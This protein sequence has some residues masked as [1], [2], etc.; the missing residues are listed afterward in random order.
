LSHYS[1]QEEV[2]YGCTVSG[3]PVDLVGAE[4]I[5]GMLVNTLPVQVKVSPEQSL[6]EWL[7]QLQTQLLEMRQYEYSSLVDVQGWSEVPRGVSLFESIV[8]FENLPVPQGLREGEKS[9]K[10]VD[11]TNFYKINYPL[12]VV[13]VPVFPLVIGINYD[14]NRLEIATINGILTHF[15]ILLQNIIASPGVRL[16]DLRLLTEREQQITSVLEKEVTFNFCPSVTA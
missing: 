5:I 12:T 3:R 7:K 14:F 11:S 15:Q 16:K 2:I 4:S 9:I 8:V 13:V 6:L 1:N 10:V